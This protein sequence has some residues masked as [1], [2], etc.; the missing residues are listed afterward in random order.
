[1][2]W[3]LCGRVRRGEAHARIDP[4]RATSPENHRV[5]CWR[6]FWFI[7]IAERTKEA[8]R[9]R[10]WWWKQWQWWSRGSRDWGRE[11]EWVAALTKWKK[12]KGKL[13]FGRK[14]GENKGVILILKIKYVKCQNIIHFYICII[15][16]I[17]G[18]FSIFIH[19]GSPWCGEGDPQPRRR[20]SYKGIF[21]SIHTPF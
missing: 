5:E 14:W 3:W 20:T 13:G 17:E 10:G 16:I 9:Q 8:G 12:W 7:A 19:M 21:A 1:M 15:Y 4:S 6:S 11:R 2:E 18:H